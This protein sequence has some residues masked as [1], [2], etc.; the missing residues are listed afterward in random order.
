MLGC[1]SGGS[2]NAGREYAGGIAGRLSGTIRECGSITALDGKAYVGGIAGSAKS[3][4]D[5]AAV[6]TMLFAGKSSFADGAYIGAIAGELTEECRNNIFAD[7]SKFNDS[8]DSVRGLGGIDGISYAGIAYAV[9]LN[10]LAEKSKNTEFVQKVTVKFSIDGKIT[11]VFEVPCGG[12]ITDLPQVGNEQGKYWRWDDFGADC[13]TFSQTVSGEWHRMITTIA[14]NEEIP[15]ILVEG[16][17]DDEA[18]VV[19]EDAAEFALKNGFGEGVPTAAFRVRVFGAEAGESTYNV[20]CL[21]EE[22]CRLSVLTDAGW[23]EREF[24]RDGKYIV[25]EL[26]NNGIF[27]IEKV[28]KKTVRPIS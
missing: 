17:F 26:N 11:E 10:E 20:R 9:S 21:S 7:T 15:Q 5:C 16:I 24:E 12:R 3:V 2:V 1:E 28:I 27:A 13:V 18:Y 19:A 22:D 4:I 23:T 14:T 6:P 8:F 25:F